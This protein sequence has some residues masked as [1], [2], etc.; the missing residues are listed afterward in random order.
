MAKRYNVLAYC[1]KCGS[2]EGSGAV[3]VTYDEDKNGI[4]VGYNDYEAS[5]NFAQQL[6]AEI[7]AIAEVVADDK[8]NGGGC[9]VN[10][11]WLLKEL[12]KLSAV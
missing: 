6:K 10:L 5:L 12:R 7:A 11:V 3:E 1:Y 8:A 9:M 2:A 4:W